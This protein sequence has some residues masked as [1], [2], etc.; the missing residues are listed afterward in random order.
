MKTSVLV[1]ATTLAAASLPA[2]AQSFF[3]D[4]HI[5]LGIGYEG[6]FDLHLHTES[7]EMEYAANELI[8]VVGTAGRTTTPPV[9]SAFAPV[10]SDIWI[11]PKTENPSLPFLGIGTEELTVSDWLGDITLTLQSVTGPGDF[12]LY[13]VGTFGEVIPLMNSRDGITSGDSVTIPAGTH[14]HFKWTFNAPGTY[15]IGFEASG[16]HAVD[17]L[18]SSGTVAYTFTAVP[19]PEEYAAMSALGLVG[20]G[21]WRRMRR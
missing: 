21:L 3:T 12:G 15:T 11:L 8:L 18:V 6:G 1:I 5:D 17:G 7:P 13:N 14:A 2:T 9:L 4:G 19:E 10:G 16:N 20:V